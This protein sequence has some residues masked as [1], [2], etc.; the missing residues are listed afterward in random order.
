MVFRD[1]RTGLTL[2]DIFTDLLH[3]MTVITQNNRASLQILAP[4]H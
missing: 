1:H 3:L 2:L 4:P